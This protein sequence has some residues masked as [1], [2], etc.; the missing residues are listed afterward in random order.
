MEPCVMCFAASFW[1]YIPKVVFAC[2]R[3]R[4]GVDYFEGNHDINALNAASRRQIQLVHLKE[5]ED[6]AFKVAA[7]WEVGGASITS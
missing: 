1:A 2:G 6:E 7:D 5:L 3:S 4:A